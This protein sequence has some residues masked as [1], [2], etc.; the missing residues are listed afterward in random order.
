MIFKSKSRVKIFR[1]HIN[2]DLN[3][4]YLVSQAGNKINQNEAT[5]LGAL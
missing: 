2:N 4:A 1:V 3:F 5:N